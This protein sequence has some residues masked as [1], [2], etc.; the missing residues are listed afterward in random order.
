MELRNKN[1][2]VVG[3]GISGLATIKILHELGAKIFI[4]DNK[5]REDLEVILKKL[6]GIP[7][8]MFLG[9]EDMELEGIDL[10]IKSPGVPPRAK[11]ISRALE[12]GIEI[13]TD[14]EL[15]YFLSA[16]KNIIAITGS[17]G[18][19]TTTHLVGETFGKAGYKTF[20]LGNI[21]VGILEKI[22]SVK[23]EDIVVIEASSFQLENTKKF[24]PKVSLVLNIS[25]DHLDWHGSYE[26]YIESKLKILKNQDIND[27]SV[28]NYDDEIVSSFAKK[29][30]ARVIWFSTKE[31]L[32]KGIYL[33]EDKIIIN[34]E[35]KI[36]LIRTDEL[37]VIGRHNLENILA[38]IG[39]FYAMGLD[40]QIIREELKNFKGVEHRLEY[41]IEKNERRFYNDSKGT[42]PDASIKAIEA[43]ESNIVLIAGGYNKSSEFDDFI[44]SFEGRV[45][46][47]ILLGATKDKIQE[48]ALR[49]GFNKNYLVEDMNE[50][51]NLAYKL[52]SAGDKVLLS[53]ACASWDMYKSFEERGMA[54]KKAVYNLGEEV[55]GKS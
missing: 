48:T 34:M 19:T 53:P 46:H 16:T 45:R 6:Q 15:G 9:Q 32:K 13:I 20:V 29:T 51:V 17:N 33:E 52:S 18:K 27:F 22:G 55:N 38:A 3:V 30:E 26:N 42:N 28:L 14:I 36:E 31:I 39:I 8:T 44:K 1:V 12:M 41:V 37:K 24:K 25:P 11:I 47:L 40:Y 2:L 54:F 50:A 7:M 49:Y 10:I 21:G 35:G 23:S 4:F 5:S 43:L